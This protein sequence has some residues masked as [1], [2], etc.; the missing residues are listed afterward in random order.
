[1]DVLQ[2][3]LSA[4]KIFR[5]FWTAANRDK[6]VIPQPVKKVT[7][8]RSFPVFL[9]DVPQALPSPL[10]S[11]IQTSVPGIM[12]ILPALTVPDM[13]ITLLMPNM[14]SGITGA[15]DVPQEEKPSGV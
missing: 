5:N 9:M 7:W 6:A 13:Q 1:M 2:G 3:F 8:W 11:K 14:A 15:A 12:A 10:W 4:K